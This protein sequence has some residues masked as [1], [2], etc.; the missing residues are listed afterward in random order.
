MFPF[1]RAALGFCAVAML[2]SKEA[3]QTLP[4]GSLTPSSGKSGSSAPLAA[5]PGGTKWVYSRTL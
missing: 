4:L 1:P 5:P 3:F 2:K